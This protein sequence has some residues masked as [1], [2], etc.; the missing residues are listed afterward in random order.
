MTIGK[1][2][3]PR[4]STTRQAD[5]RSIDLR[6]GARWARNQPTTRNVPAD[7]SEYMAQIG[8]KGVQLGGKRRLG[9]MPPAQRRKTAKKAAKVRWG[10]SR[11]S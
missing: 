6:S 7:I 3:R 1:G 8:R 11:Q 5:R 9:T 10:N 4:I 2:K